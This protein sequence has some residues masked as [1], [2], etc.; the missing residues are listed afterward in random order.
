MHAQIGCL[1]FSPAWAYSE[2]AKLPSAFEQLRFDCHA[3]ASPFADDSIN[4]QGIGLARFLA[5]RPAPF[6]VPD[7]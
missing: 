3:T 2:S 4:G 6:D 7:G 1:V 5:H